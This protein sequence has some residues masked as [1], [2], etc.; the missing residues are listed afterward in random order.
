MKLRI[1]ASDGISILGMRGSGKT[2]LAVNLAHILSRTFRVGFIDTVGAF[3]EYG[4]DRY[5]EVFYVDSLDLQTLAN[6][7]D[8]FYK[9][10]PI[11]IFVDEA[12]EFGFSL[13][14]PLRT[15]VKRGRNWGAGYCAIFQEISKVDKSILRNS[16][17]SF[18]GR[19]T[20]D[21]ESLHS[22]VNRIQ[23]V[24]DVD[25]TKLKRGE[26]FIAHYGQIIYS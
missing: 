19:H 12:D 16:T 5:G 13:E 2:T 17:W 1:K 7:L 14:S 15:L 10:A 4:A 26:F 8:Y 25:S 21:A 22:E 23:Y 24:Y 18:I 6:T 3:R 20:N 11:M 9:K